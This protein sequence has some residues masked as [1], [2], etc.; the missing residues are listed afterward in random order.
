MINMNIVCARIFLCAGGGFSNDDVCY[1]LG[2][3]SVFILDIFCHI[4]YGNEKNSFNLVSKKYHQIVQ[5]FTLNLSVHKPNF[6]TTAPIG[7]ILGSKLADFFCR[8]FSC[9]P[10][11]GYLFGIFFKTN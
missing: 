5:Y 2:G 11:K 3:G 10:N 1:Q 6:A 8:I 7:S 4:F 9:H